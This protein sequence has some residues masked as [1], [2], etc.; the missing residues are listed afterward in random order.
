MQ[1]DLARENLGLKVYDCYRPKRA[2]AAMARWAQGEK[3]R[4][5]PTKRFSSRSSTKTYIVFGLGYIA[6]QSAHSTGTA[7]DLTLV[8]LPRRRRR[9]R[10]TAP[11]ITGPARDRRRQR[12]P[13]TSLDMGTGFDCFDT[14]SNTSSDAISAEQ[15]RARAALLLA[16]RAHG[17]HNYFREWWHYSFTAAAE[18]RSYDFA[19]VPKGR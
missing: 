3:S 13:D 11:R 2:V 16:M 8:K 5:Q 9:R 10:S 4:D 12:A 1:A 7:I 18:P 15:R 17:F 14:R 6:A 19:I